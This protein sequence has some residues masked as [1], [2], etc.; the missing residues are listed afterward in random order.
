MAPRQGRQHA[1]SCPL[2]ALPVPYTPFSGPLQGGVLESTSAG[3][4][5]QLEIAGPPAGAGAGDAAQPP[6]EAI[7]I[8][9]D[10]EDEPDPALAAEGGWRDDGTRDARAAAG[11]A[12]GIVERL[13]A[14]DTAGAAS[15][16]PWLCLPCHARSELP[17]L[18]VRA[19]AAA[20]PFARI[21]RWLAA[22]GI[23]FPGA[24]CA[25]W[26]AEGHDVAP[27]QE[28]PAGPL[29]SLLASARDG[30]GLADALTAAVRGCRGALLGE[31]RPNAGDP[32]PICTEDI[33][34]PGHGPSATTACG[35]TFHEACIRRWEAAVNTGCWPYSGAPTCPVCRSPLAIDGYGCP[36]P[37]RPPPLPC[38]GRSGPAPSRHCASWP[39]QTPVARRLTIPSPEC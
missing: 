3:W 34:D 10:T 38:G 28:V 24:L 16:A 32:C 29:A 14:A 8:C 13:S 23:D 35:H 2:E 36:P 33:S 30:G 19:R 18:L 37:A 21:T 27:Y 25:H 4:R 5:I 17:R 7:P 26:A 6:P 9:T 11:L 15:R 39:G 22:E 1:S 12:D 31:V 20:S